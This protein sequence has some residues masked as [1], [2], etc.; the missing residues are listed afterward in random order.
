MS[1]QV[2]LVLWF[3]VHFWLTVTWRRARPTQDDIAVASKVLGKARG[4]HVVFVAEAVGQNFHQD[5]APF[6]GRLS[7]TRGRAAPAVIIGHHFR[8]PARA[9]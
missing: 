3:I 5:A 2:S 8:V 6:H 7:S 9:G 1:W 4:I